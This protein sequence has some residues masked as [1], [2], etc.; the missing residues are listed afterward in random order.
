M[1][2]DENKEVLMQEVFGEVRYSVEEV[3]SPDGLLSYIV[4]EEELA[5]DGLIREIDMFYSKD[6]AIEFYND[7][8]GLKY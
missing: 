8:M 7:L 2:L 4:S 3:C 6:E 5:N 1:L